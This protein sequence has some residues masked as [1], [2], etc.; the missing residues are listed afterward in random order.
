MFVTAPA[1]QPSAALEAGTTYFF[2]ITAV[3][4]TVSQQAVGT[5]IT[6]TPPAPAPAP[7]PPVVV[8]EQPAQPA[9]VINIPPAQQVAPAYI[10][11]IVIIGA[12]LIIA[13]IVLIVR[14]RRPM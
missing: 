2:G 9:P 5:F 1:W 13:V 4:P 12:I 11:A 3:E 7:A 14:T 6:A 8:K 10:W